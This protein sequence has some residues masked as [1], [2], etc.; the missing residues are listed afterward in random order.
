MPFFSNPTTRAHHLAWFLPPLLFWGLIVLPSAMGA[1]WGS[2]DDPLV[3][4]LA[5]APFLDNLT[6]FGERMIPVHFVNHWLFYA[7]AG[8]NPEFWYLFQSLEFL[9]LVLLIYLGVSLAT[10]RPWLGAGSASFFLISSPI[11][12]NAYT[13]S[14]SESIMVLF[15]GLFVLVVVM[16]KNRMNG[17]KGKSGVIQKGFI[18]LAFMIV[19]LLAIFS[20]ETAVTFIL[21]GFGG[22]ACGYVY[23]KVDNHVALH[24]FLLVT[25]AAFLSNVLFFCLKYFLSHGQAEGYT[26]FVPSLASIEANFSFYVNQTPDVLLLGLLGFF[27]CLAGFAAFD[28]RNTLTTALAWGMWAGGCAQFAILLAWRWPLAYYMLPVGICFNFSLAFFCS[29]LL[30]SV[31][32]RPRSWQRAFLVSMPVVLLISAI[33]SIPY[34]HFI[35]HA[36]RGFDR[37]EDV[38]QN[39]IIEIDP[40]G[41]RVVDMDRTWFTEPPLQR[42]R[43]FHEKGRPDLRWVGAGELFQGFSKEQQRLYGNTTLPDL[44]LNPLIKGDLVLF[45]GSRYPFNNALRGI[46]NARTEPPDFD[47]KKTKAEQLTGYRFREVFRM[48][49]ATKVFS[50]LTFQPE[51][52]VFQGVLY[53]ATKRLPTRYQWEGHYGD[54]TGK[55]ALLKLKVLPGYSMGSLRISIPPDKRLV[56]ALLPLHVTLIG[57][58]G[59]TKELV[60]HKNALVHEIDVSELLKSSEGEIKLSVSKTWRPSDLGLGQD[61]R[62]LGVMAEYLSDNK[63]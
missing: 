58:N 9:L 21:V 46:G 15:Y 13:I 60:L 33:Y 12:E 22:M 24:L 16:C 30:D 41:K 8:E 2:L 44:T 29:D 56:D 62:L 4:I 39:R 18:T 51:E 50:P 26:S 40:A 7:L 35:A 31:K 34:I 1:V 5:R 54:Y 10:G 27:G 43:L 17:K 3:L 61:G 49:D 63:P 36:Q 42:T 32:V 53:E 48:E 38:I 20:K 14:K 6:G 55:E 57:Q 37:V 25:L 59:L 23:R 52:L 11:A 45:Q 47:L 19:I 28:R